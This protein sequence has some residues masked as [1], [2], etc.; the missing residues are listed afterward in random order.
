LVCHGA[1]VVLCDGQGLRALEV[2][3]RFGGRAVDWS[4]RHDMAA[5]VLVN[6]TPIGMRPD[7]EQ[8]P[9]AA[10]WLRPSMIVFDA[11][12]NPESTRLLADARRAGCRV[13]CGV[14]M[15]VRQAC[16]QFKLFTGRQ[17][18]ATL[19]RDVLR[20]ALASGS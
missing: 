8:T 17:P 15:F 1:E 9:Y 3:R 20:Q 14:D 10:G 19:M 5:D 7:V 11:V 4:A 18:P 12:Y 13:A 6:C 2:A 16:L